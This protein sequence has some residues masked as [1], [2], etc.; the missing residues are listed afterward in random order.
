MSFSIVDCQKTHQVD[1]VKQYLLA[2]IHGRRLDGSAFGCKMT[3][4]VLDDFGLLECG[5]VTHGV[6]VLDYKYNRFGS[7]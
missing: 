5:V 4:F 2:N 7:E 6:I 3:I 1:D